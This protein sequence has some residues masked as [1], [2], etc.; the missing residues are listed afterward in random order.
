MIGGH[1]SLMHYSLNKVFFQNCPQPSIHDLEVYFETLAL[2]G[3]Q[4]TFFVI[5]KKAWELTSPPEA[6]TRQVVFHNRIKT[7]E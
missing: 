2:Q 3:F 5:V 1:Y 7:I 4:N 6:L